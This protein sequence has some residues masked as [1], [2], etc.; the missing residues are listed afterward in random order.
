[1]TS[2][3]HTWPYG[4]FIGIQSNHRRKKLHRTNQ[5]SNLLGSSFSNRNNVSPNPI[6]KRKSTP[7]SQNMILPH[8]QTHPFSYQWLYCYWIGQMKPVSFPE[9]SLKRNQFDFQHWNQQAT[10][11]P[12]PS[13]LVDQI[14]VQKLILV[15]DCHRSDAWSHLEQRVVS[16]A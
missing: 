9:V 10:S 7:V 3:F 13:C 1:M 11:C 12:S 5:S 4:R 8:E 15:I 6:Y 14:Q 16:L 2:V